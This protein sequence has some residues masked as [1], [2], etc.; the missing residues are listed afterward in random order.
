MNNLDYT[1]NLYDACVTVTEFYFGTPKD[2]AVQW[3][4]DEEYYTELNVRMVILKD[5]MKGKP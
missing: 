4:T 5:A 3:M 2:N 1:Q